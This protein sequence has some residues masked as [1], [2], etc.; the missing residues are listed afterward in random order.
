MTKRL[1]WI[2]GV[3]T[4]LSACNSEVSDNP[5]I[6]INEELKATS[7]LES[8][9]STVIHITHD[10]HI[11]LL[12]ELFHNA[13]QLDGIV[14]MADPQYRIQLREKQ[15]NV[16]FN[17]D[18]TAVFTD[19]EDT[20]TLYK[21]SDAAKLKEIIHEYSFSMNESPPTLTITI[22]EHIIQTA[23]GLHSWSYIDRKTGEQTGIEAQSLSP[24]EIVNLENAKLV[25]LN[26]PINLNFEHEPDRYDIRIWSSDNKVSATYKDLSDIKEKGKIVCEILATWQQGTASYAFALDIQ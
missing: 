6:H 15:Y 24:T 18:G 26:K 3:A 12:E 10:S 7:N 16:W 5:S 25:D 4:I 14:N 1:I 20:H 11:V 17:E 8:M 19:I 21:I 23:L 2:I 22:G 9:N 13:I